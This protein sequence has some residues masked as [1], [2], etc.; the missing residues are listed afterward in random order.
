MIESW[1]YYMQ[2]YRNSKNRTLITKYTYNRHMA[3]MEKAERDTKTK[4]KI[5]DHI[6]RISI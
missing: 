5:I 6:K 3:Y 2:K 1:K 4:G